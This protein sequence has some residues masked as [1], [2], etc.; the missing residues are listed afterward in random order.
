[1]LQKGP[2]PKAINLK[3]APGVALQDRLLRAEVRA[4]AEC[5]NKR[6]CKY[7]IAHKRQERDA[8]M[9]TLKSFWHT[10][11]LNEYSSSLCLDGNYI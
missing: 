8:K 11:S 4:G 9:H 3:T 2:Q 1:M 10:S 5:D 6:D 7:K